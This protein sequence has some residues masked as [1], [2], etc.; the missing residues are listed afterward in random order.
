VTL[1]LSAGVPLLLGG[2]ELGRTQRGNNNAYCQDNELAWL[3]WDLS[4]SQR[5]FL[6]FVRRVVA[7]RQSQPVFQRR[8]FFEGV[9]SEGAVVKDLYWLKPDGT[10]MWGDD[11]YSDAQ[12]I[13]VGLIGDQIEEVDR[14]GNRIVGSTL[15]MLLNAS[16]EAVVFH[17]PPGDAVWE[18]LIDTAYP[19]G[20]PARSISATPTS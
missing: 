10:E 13:G 9:P 18:L 2:D 16:D 4:P 6:A 20:R 11:W 8:K 17:A 12:A 5:E 3:D 1:L 19:D 7:I 15:V 14:E